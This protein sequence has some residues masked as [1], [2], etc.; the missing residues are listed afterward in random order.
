MPEQTFDMRRVLWL[1]RRRR[2]MVAVFVLVGALIPTALML[3]RP[4]Q[5]TATSLVL[6]PTASATAGAGG[7][8]ASTTNG[9]VTD[10]ALAVSSAVLGTAGS[11]VTPRVT[12][13]AAQDRVSAT[14]VATNLVQI[15]ATGTNP[16]AAEA[17][18]NAVA[19]RLVV[20]VTSSNI[21]GGSSQLSG[22]EAEAAVDTKLV[23]KYDQEIA[24]VQAAIQANPSAPIAQQDTQLLG[25]LNTAQTA[26]SLNLETVQNNI[27]TA[28]QNSAA[29]NGGTEVVQYASSAAGPSL[30]HR[31]LPIVIGAVV[32]FLVGAVFV[33]LRQRKSN[34]TTRDEMAA[35]AGVPVVLSVSVGHVGKSSEWLTLLREQETSVSELW[36]VR[37]VLNE[38]EVSEGG[39]R[40]LTVISLADD[41]PSMA[42]VAHLAVACAAMEISTSLVLT[43]DDQGARGLNEA[44]DLL[45]ARNEAP[46]PRLRLFKGSSTV[47]EVEDELTIISI[48]LNPDLPKLPAFVAR[49]IVMMAITAGFVGQ[50]QLARA[51]IAIGQ[52]GL[53]VK[54]LFV[55]NP[56][57][58]DKT[59]GSIPNA[60][61]QVTR[62]FQSRA[63]EPWTG[64]GDVR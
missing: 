51:L 63:L 27:A 38:V 23:N 39:G 2:S 19:N 55:A 31:A 4:T 29:T 26:A 50:D 35:V 54:G 47:E 32:G 6:V 40:V 61:Q 22:L 21:A 59:L 10:S 12:L 13:Q 41:G 17:L 7:A 42:A 14:P 64:G 36:N 58:G 1:L 30:L 46:R 52:E 5:Y 11:R 53:S 45:T 18:A 9:N 28:K 37:K 34:L 24:S 16:R 8:T 49:G 57:S 48:V 33:V 20:F 44:C 56:M 62:F 60:N 43:S 15:T 3:S 25:S